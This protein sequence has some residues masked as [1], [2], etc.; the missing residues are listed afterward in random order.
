MAAWKWVLGYLV[1]RHTT[2]PDPPPQKS[3]GELGYPTWIASG[4]MLTVLCLPLLWIV[5]ALP[6]LVVGWF[7]CFA[8]T[9]L[10]VIG[11]CAT[12]YQERHP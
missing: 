2:R 11:G 9:W 1:I 3:T 12:R 4:V 5:W 7:M 6:F 8:F 10:F